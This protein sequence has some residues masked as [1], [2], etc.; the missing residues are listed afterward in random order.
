MGKAYLI[1]MNP[2][3][4]PN[5]INT[6]IRTQISSPNRQMIYL[7]ILTKIKHKMK[8]GTIDQEKIMDCGVYRGD[9]TEH[10]W[11]ICAG[12]LLDID[13]LTWEKRIVDLLSRNTV[14]ITLTLNSSK[15]IGGVE[16][17]VDG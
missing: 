14:E 2:I 17:E 1:I 11:S 16:F 13:F 7:N 8:F 9:E 3:V 15:T 12:G 10:S 6:I 5:S 4:R